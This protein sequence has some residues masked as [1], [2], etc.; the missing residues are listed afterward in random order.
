MN[1]FM[2]GEQPNYYEGDCWRDEES[3]QMFS[4]RHEQLE[5]AGYEG[6]Y[7]DALAGRFDIDLHA[8]VELVTVRGCPT[9]TALR[10]L[11]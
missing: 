3:R 8:A 10:V 6:E 1:G 2:S 7:A 9:R 5:R 4:W 11:L